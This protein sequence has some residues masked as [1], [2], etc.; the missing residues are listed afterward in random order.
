MIYDCFTFFNNFDI[1]EIRLNELNDVVDKF[2][3][4]EA[5]ETFSRQ[6]KE[7]LFDQNRERYSKFLDKI[8][9][10]PIEFPKDLDPYWASENYQ[11]NEITRGLVGCLPDDIIIISD[12]DEIPRKTL[13]TK[14]KLP[15]INEQLNYDFIS[16]NQHARYYFLNY[17]DSFHWYGSM[18]VSYN[19]LCQNSSQ[20]LRNIRFEHGIKIENGGWHFSYME[21]VEKIQL[22]LK[23]ACHT[24]FSGEEYSNTEKLTRC[25]N[26]GR[27]FFNED[28]KLKHI[29]IEEC[30]LPDYVKQNLDKFEKY[31]KR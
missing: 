11:K 21:D 23:S 4:V 26:E 25:L 19:G 17:E 18:V 27:M 30:D 5:N 29:P 2:V 24:E 9:Y 7:F 15:L 6:P 13:F 22:K 20:R 28:I 8:I 14:D 16:I 31:I 12:V 1:L 10:V 3:L